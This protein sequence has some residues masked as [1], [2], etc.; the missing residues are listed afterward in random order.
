MSRAV[1]K[2]PLGT[3]AIV[4]VPATAVPVLVAL[5]PATGQPGIWLE[6]DLDAPKVERTFGIFGTGHTIEGNGGYPS[7]LHVGSVVQGLYVWHVYE[8]R[9]ATTGGADHG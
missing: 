6:I 1:W 4:S 3:L 2:F 9:A 7:P 5:D 8:L